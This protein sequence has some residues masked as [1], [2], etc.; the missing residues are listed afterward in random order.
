MRKRVAF[1][2]KRQNRLGMVCVMLVVLMVLVVIL[3]KNTELRAKKAVYEERTRQIEEQIAF[4]EKRAEEL[5][6][7]EKYTK[8]AKYVEEVAKD[9]LGLVY[10]DEIV[11]ESEDEK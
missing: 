8:T 7:Y 9:K 1:R 2:R 4:E 5:V 3:V 6:E 10:Q 11:F